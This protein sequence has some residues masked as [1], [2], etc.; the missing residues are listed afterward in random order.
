MS[1]RR[2][3][4]E[5][6]G[7]VVGAGVVGTVHARALSRIAGVRLAAICGRTRL[8]TERLAKAHG[9][10]AYISIAEMLT[11]ERPDFVCICTGNKD[12]FEPALACLDAGAHV[13]V[14][15]PMAFLLDEARAMVAE[16]K[17]EGLRIGVNFNHRF[18][19]PYERALDFVSR[20]E[21]GEPAYLMMKFAGDLYP[22]LNDPYCQLIE[23]QGHSFD[24]LRLFGGEIIE[25][26][27]FLADPRGIGIYT[28]AALSMGFASGAVG[29]LLGSWDSSYEHPSAQ[30][31]EM[32]GTEGRIVVDNIVD[33]VRLFRHGRDS[34][35]H[36]KP[37]LF[38]SHARDFWGT[39]QAH[40]AVFV[41]ALLEGRSP[42]VS[43]AD[44]LRA[45][46]L[47]YAAIESFEKSTSLTCGPEGCEHRP[48]G[49]E[50]TEG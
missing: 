16:A 35:T 34:F 18:S 47:T 25:L 5:L 31:L 12:H 46:E 21:I 9:V 14:E 17:S 1:P 48:R 44:G 50:A 10:R 4:G 41:Q 2:D 28:S 24:L 20:G 37:P 38:D 22:D 29:T 40:L 36:W 13:F 3:K 45:L 26:R 30:V 49:P 15:K 7:A 19:A 11:T 23:T 42:P 8:K 32:S 6:V 43:G 27:A 39:I 33:G